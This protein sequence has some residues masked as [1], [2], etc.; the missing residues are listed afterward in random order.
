MSQ[1]ILALADLPRELYRAEQVRQLDRLAIDA[2]T[3]GFELMS[4]AG[5]A[6]FQY[7]QKRWPERSPLEVFCGGGN[8]GGDGYVIAALAAQSGV[9]VRLWAM[10][11]NLQGD[12]LLARQMAEQAGL[13]A[14]PWQ[15]ETIAGDALVV[16]AL[17][18]TGL[19]GDV[20]PAYRQ[21]IEAIN[22]SGA[23]VL[24]VDIPS[25]LCSDSGRVLGA[26]VAADATISFIG[27]K[28]GLFTGEAADYVGELV[29]NSLAVARDIYTQVPV[30]TFLSRPADSGGLLPRRRR[31]SHKGS[32]GHVLVVGGDEGMAGAALLAASAAAR[33]GAGLVSCATRGAHLAAFTAARPEI[34]AKA[35]DDA[36]QLKPLLACCSV[37]VAGPGLGSGA[38]GRALLAEVLGAGKPMV[39][40]ADALNILA[41]GELA[42]AES[43]LPCVIT[44]HPAEAARLLG[45]TTADVQ[46][47]RFAAAQAL[48]QRFHCGALLKGAGTLIA[49]GQQCF[50]NCSGN[51]GMASGGMGDVLSG[52]IGALLA[53]G[54]SATDA[55]RL[56]ASLHGQAADLVAARMGERGMLALD[57][58]EAIPRVINGYSLDA[59]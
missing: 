1:N 37:V 30:D 47:D 50:V 29:F 35:V 59:G 56:G 49:D 19:A 12:A 42:L 10:S 3:P 8:N 20:R 11:A 46:Q 2:G 22:E 45:G 25:G 32:F 33:S 9:P 18:G 55:A 34:M 39:L 5:L 6:A 31:V 27:L 7:L 21:V 38:W 43:G 51:P 44:P 28:Q 23:V 24:A 26:A 17:L 54:L 57:V 15:G 36:D 4:R 40:D 48:A 53:Q 58:V 16:D 52:M 13:V 41:E 14:Q